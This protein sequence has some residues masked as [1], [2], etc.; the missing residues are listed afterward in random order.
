MSGTQGIVTANGGLFG[1]FTVLFSC[2]LVDRNRVYIIIRWSALTLFPSSSGFHFFM[3][4]RGTVL[5]H[6]ENLPSKAS[7]F[8]EGGRYGSFRES[9]RGGAKS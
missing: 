6:K 5:S 4:P 2:F 8:F 1:F 7:A 3:N 9:P